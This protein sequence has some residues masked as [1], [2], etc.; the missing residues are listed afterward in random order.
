MRYRRLFS[1]SPIAS[2]ALI[3]L[4]LGLA[5][6]VPGW[7]QSSPGG[8]QAA[9]PINE[10]VLPL[11]E[12]A[13]STLEL[14][15]M[16]PRRVIEFSI[17]R[18]RFVTEARLDLQLT[19]SP[20]LLDG[21]SQLKIYLNDELMDAIPLE[22]DQANGAQRHTLALDPGLISD[23]NRLRLE[24]VGHYAKTCEDPTHSSI[25]VNISGDSTLSLRE[26]SL[27]VGNDLS[28]LLLPFF[29]D[30][31]DTPLE[32][33]IVLPASP[34]LEMQR[35]GGIVASYF[36][37]QAK[38][39]GQNFPVSF[40][41]A[42]TQ[43]SVVLATNEQ[44]PEILAD[45]PPVEGPTIEMISHPDSPFH[46][47]L[48]LMGRDE[49]DLVTAA[50]GLAL[51]NPLLRG[52]SAR[53]DA[54]DT[55]EPRQPYDAPA[56]I[57]TDRPVTFAELLDYPT[58]LQTSG[59]ELDPV[60][61]E[62]TL[63]PDLFIWRNEL[64]RLQLDYRHSPPPRGADSRLD[65]T[66]NDEFLKSF[67]LE[68]GGEENKRSFLQVPLLKNWLLPGQSADIPALKIGPR[69]IMQF[70]FVY[71]DQSG[72]GGSEEECRPLVSPPHQASVDKSSSLDFS[73]YPHYL[74]MP[75]LR[76][77][78]Y[79]G[80]PFSRLADLSQTLVIMPESP[81]ALQLQALFDTLGRIGAQTG[82]P[83]VAVSLSD[84]WASAREVD[85][86]ILAFGSLP[87]ELED[88]PQVI[89]LGEDARSRLSL[90]D[91][92]EEDARGQKRV[93]ADRAISVTAQGAIASVV[94]LKSPFFEQRSIVALLAETPADFRLLNEALSDPALRSQIR[95]SVA[96]IRDSG[97][98]NDVV[99]E[100]YHIG[101]LPWT[102]WLWY[103]L[104]THPW[105]MAGIA[106]LAILL[107]ALLLWALLRR[108]ST[109][110][111]SRD[112]D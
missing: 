46:K 47:L 74:E 30:N 101:E 22:V 63:P 100:R 35:A 44:R 58:Q 76:T 77:F 56:W 97:V 82:Y 29:D 94:E 32:L 28:N 49:A 21:V 25:W 33:P 111:L 12:L 4:L 17:R 11:K 19:P 109:R 93:A 71:A 73:G 54:L 36:G 80:F 2:S 1:S 50:R 112:E 20:S 15:G 31:D 38:W 106:L 57:P 70:H 75:A 40:D 69:N 108:L 9:P 27:P 48:I 85:A 79:A 3:L 68:G 52:L 91:V 66:I 16:S 102:S 83:G 89:A 24:L 104:S 84:G 55:L 23:F 51:G 107:V 7:A 62:L 99:G 87:E 86:D 65:V 5:A 18:D 92:S 72:V 110:R 6:A 53:I 26:Q 105:L 78:T 59:R 96:V 41:T 95:G 88:E 34:P 13:Q 98:R 103:H 60:H 39:R 67:P 45:Y 43:H 14:S 37:S 90:A 8:G 42:P 61:V 10:R 64:T 81:S